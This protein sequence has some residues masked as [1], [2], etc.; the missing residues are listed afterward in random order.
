MIVHLKIL[1]LRSTDTAILAPTG[2]PRFENE[3]RDFTV[4][5]CL[6]NKPELALSITT[7]VASRYYHVER[8]GMSAF[9]NGAR[10]SPGEE[11]F[12]RSPKML[13]NAMA[14]FSRTFPLHAIYHFGSPPA[15]ASIAWSLSPRLART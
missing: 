15:N 7:T 1:I 6:T 12:I 4:V 8:T 14:T 5:S 9:S 2:R 3:C 11:N 10:L 13:R